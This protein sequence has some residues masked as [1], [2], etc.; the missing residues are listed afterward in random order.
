MH[1]LADECHRKPCRW[2]LTDD[3]NRNLS[4]DYPVQLDSEELRVEGESSHRMTLEDAKQGAVALTLYRYGH[5]CRPGAQ[6]DDPFEFA[7]LDLE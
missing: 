1:H 3:V 4:L 5:Q 7:R 2:C 6:V